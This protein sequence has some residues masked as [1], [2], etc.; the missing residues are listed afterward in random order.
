M[1]KV[2]ALLGE[3]SSVHIYRP[4][5][6]SLEREPLVWPNYHYYK[7]CRSMSTPSSVELVSNYLLLLG[8]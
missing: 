6:T 5:T 8:T 7:R 3:R 1:Q 4:D 2:L